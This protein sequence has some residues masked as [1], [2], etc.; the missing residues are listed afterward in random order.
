[1][2]ISSF[3]SRSDVAHNAIQCTYGPQCGGLIAQHPTATVLLARRRSRH[4]KC[5]AASDPVR[6]SYRDAL[7]WGA[8]S[9]DTV[10][11]SPC[12][13]HLVGQTRSGPR[14]DIRYYRPRKG[15]RA[16]MDILEIGY[17]FIPVPPISGYGPTEA[18]ISCVTEELVK[19]GHR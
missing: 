5:Q 6:F 13:R 18:V 8:L 3:L 9:P 14:F 19:E 1:M 10:S 2:R 15:P 7:I 11:S 4:H 16:L 17:P 12:P